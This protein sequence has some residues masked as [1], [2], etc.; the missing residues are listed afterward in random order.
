M[1]IPV[2]RSSQLNLGRAIDV[3]FCNFSK[4]LNSKIFSVKNNSK[5]CNIFQGQSLK[6]ESKSATRFTLKASATAQS[7]AAVISEKGSRN[8]R[9]KPVSFFF[10]PFSF[11]PLFLFF[12][13]LNVSF[14]II[15]LIYVKILSRF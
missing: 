7:E 9:T 3:G 13:L 5:T 15:F 4:N 6:W 10:S 12:S 11:F 14:L 8:S 2:I 1:E